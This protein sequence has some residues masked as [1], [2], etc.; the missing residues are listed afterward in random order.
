MSAFSN[1]SR[2]A[3]H[4]LF[5][6]HRSNH[7]SART[8]RNRKTWQAD[9][10]HTGCCQLP[11]QVEPLMLNFAIAVPRSLPKAVADA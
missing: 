8:H 11:S 2:C 7:S 3:H 6:I 10:L 9:K 5:R 4:W 1:L